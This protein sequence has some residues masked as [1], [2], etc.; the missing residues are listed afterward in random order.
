[1]PRDAISGRQRSASLAEALLA[2]ALLAIIT[3]GLLE[4]RQRLADYPD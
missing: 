1:M 4:Y 3:L 2:P